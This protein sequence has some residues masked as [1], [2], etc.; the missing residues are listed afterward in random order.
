[1]GRFVASV[2]PLALLLGGC[3]PP[4][5]NRA[6]PRRVVPPPALGGTVKAGRPVPALSGGTL[7]LLR[8]GRTAVVAD[9][10][11]DRIFVVDLKERA[12]LADLPLEAGDEPGRSVVDETGTVHVVLRRG[13]AILSLRSSGGSWAVVARR[14]V[15]AAP[16]GIAYEVHDDLLHVACADGLLVSLPAVGGEPVRSVPL[17]LDLRD[18]VVGNGQLL[19]SRFRS[20]EVLAVDG[21]GTVTPLSL[22]PLQEMGN[23]STATVAW[24]M[25]GYGDGRALMVHQ[26]ALDGVVQIVSG[27]YGGSMAT[28][29]QLM[30]SAVSVVRSDGGSLVARLRNTVLPIDLDVSPDGR[31][32]AVVAAGAAHTRGANQIV[33]ASTDGPPVT[34][35]TSSEQVDANHQPHGEAVAVA[36]LPDGELAVQT[37]E[38]AALELLGTGAVIPLSGE[39]RADT[40]HAI[41]HSTA[42]ALLACASCHPEGGDDGHVWTFAGLGERRTQSLRGGISMTAPFH[43]DGNLA[44]LPQLYEEVLT[45]RM[46]GP[47]LDVGQQQALT[48][49]IDS[50]PGLPGAEPSEASAR[51]AM[52][53]ASAGCPACHNGPA[54]TNNLTVDVGTGGSFQ[55]PSLR[56][57]RWRAPYLHGGCAA[58]LS[59]RFGTCG[60]D[61]HGAVSL[62]SAAQIVDLVAYL[63][64]L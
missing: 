12:V 39:S 14:P 34:T 25:R 42:G 63:E 21:D 51:G 11:R 13:G 62:L 10:D 58:T 52:V 27:G 16:R 47:R 38:P 20:S 9:P 33:L 53:F 17:P 37:R 46:S 59:D 45:K 19:V 18:V 7:T 55:T 41:F 22:P 54:M 31:Q 49:W 29:G 32:V 56:G 40:G 2:V 1:M 28:C 4:P 5:Q 50:I 44:G 35:C 43:W 60:G 26:Y 8:D 64:T 48:S 6:E 61:R 36:Y 23:H 57:V 24:R 30:E 15:C 3:P